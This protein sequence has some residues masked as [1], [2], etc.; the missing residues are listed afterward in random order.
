AQGKDLLLPTAPWYRKR[1]ITFSDMLAAARRRHF[2]PG[3][4]REPGKHHSSPK[5][6]PPRFT[7]RPEDYEREKL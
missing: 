1:N 2:I 3:I 6:M 7:R 4:S 5:I